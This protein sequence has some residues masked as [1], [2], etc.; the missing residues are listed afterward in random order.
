[1]TDTELLN[2]LQRLFVETPGVAVLRT[3]RSGVK[4]ELSNSAIAYDD[5]TAHPS[6]LREYFGGMNVRMAIEAAI[7]DNEK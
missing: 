5:T 1:M 2:G 7:K 3:C 4:I 6:N